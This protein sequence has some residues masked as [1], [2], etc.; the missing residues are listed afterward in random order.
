VHD[1][2]LL[3]SRGFRCVLRIE[4]YVGLWIVVN[5]LDLAPQ[6]ATRSIDFVY[7]EIERRNH[8]LS[9]DVEAAR[10]VVDA[11]DLHHVLR[12]KIAD[13]KWSGCQS[14]GTRRRRSEKLPTIDHKAPL[15]LMHDACC[16]NSA[17]AGKG[18]F[19]LA[20]ATVSSTRR[21]HHL[22]RRAKR[23]LYH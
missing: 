11:G 4:L 10:G 16:K 5:Q 8:L 7:R 12:V 19:A 15:L 22:Q 21:A 2:N 1:G 18:G 9:I 6:Q 14:G 3:L 13:D 17:R 20:L 23:W